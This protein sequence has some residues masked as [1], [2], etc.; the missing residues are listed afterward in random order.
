VKVN[1]GGST[2][3]HRGWIITEIIGVT[4]I[5]RRSTVGL[6]LVDLFVDLLVDLPVDY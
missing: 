5:N 6:R 3:D 2:K 1:L 4:E